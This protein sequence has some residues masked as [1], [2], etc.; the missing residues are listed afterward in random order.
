NGARET[1]TTPNPLTEYGFLVAT[2]DSRSAA[3]RGK[4]FLDAIYMK[5]GTVEIDDQAAGVKSLWGRPYVDRTRVG[6]F[7]TSYGGFA[8]LLALVRHPDVFQAASGSLPVAGWNHYDTHYT[9][10]YMWIPQ[11]DKEGYGAG[12]AVE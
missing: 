8:S 6:I 10:R 9:Q 4:R 7:G 11:E 3:G 5:L 12:S 1:F 2:L